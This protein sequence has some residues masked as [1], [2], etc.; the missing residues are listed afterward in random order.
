MSEILTVCLATEEATVKAFLTG[1]G[2]KYVATYGP[3]DADIMSF[4]KWESPNINI[5]GGINRSGSKVLV[6][7]QA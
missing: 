3:F 7:T 4:S 6:H 2:Q 1:Q 5:I